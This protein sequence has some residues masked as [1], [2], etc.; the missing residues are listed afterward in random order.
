MFYSET[1]TLFSMAEISWCALAAPPSC[2][3][4]GTQAMPH[5]SAVFKNQ[6][7]VRGVAGR[8]SGGEPV[9]DILYE[10]YGVFSSY[11]LPYALLNWACAPFEAILN[12]FMS[13]GQYVNIRTYSRIE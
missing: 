1:E 3:G 10:I 2:E 6:W 8:Q 9:C 4:E 7:F 11:F 5:T 12:V 13:S